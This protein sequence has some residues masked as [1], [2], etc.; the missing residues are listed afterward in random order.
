MDKVD[1]LIIGLSKDE[2]LNNWVT[3]VNTKNEDERNKNAKDKNANDNYLEIKSFDAFKN[4]KKNSILSFIEKSE[5]THELK[6][7]YKILLDEKNKNRLDEVVLD[8]NTVNWMLQNLKLHILKSG[9]FDE[10]TI[11]VKKFTNTP[12]CQMIKRILCQRCLC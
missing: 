7:K 6:E 5:N 9:D 8:I 3:G 12:K 2:N 11:I 10:V 4:M 1:K